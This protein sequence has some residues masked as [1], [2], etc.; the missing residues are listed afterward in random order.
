MQPGFDLRIKAMNRAMKEVVL[1]A[2]GVGNSTAVEQA[3]IIMATLEMMRDQIDHAHWFEVED[4][5][6]LC[7]FA[8]I[9][10]DAAG[11]PPDSALCQ[12]AADAKP[13]TARH[14]LTLSTLKTANGKLR[15]AICTFIDEV[16]DRDDAALQTAVQEIILTRSE[17]DIGR[18]RAYVA[19]ANWD[20]FP[21][22]LKPLHEALAG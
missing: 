12:A 10:A 2:I 17:K 9:L 16:F 5:L 8:Q 4:L 19:K 11:L 21:E 1:P 6:S 13:L 22:S 20:V 14:D 18:E 7:D 3:S 15:D